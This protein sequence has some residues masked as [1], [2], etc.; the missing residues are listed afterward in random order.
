MDETE[1]K[2]YHD[3]LGMPFTVVGCGIDDILRLLDMYDTFMPE[4]VAQGL[5]PTDKPARLAWIRN[6]LERGENYA[7]IIEGKV[8]G[9]GVLMPGRERHEG[10]YVIFVVRPYRKRGLATALTEMVIQRA[11]ALGLGSVW[12]TV[13]SDNFKAIKLYTKMGFH[14]CDE[15]LSERQ[16]ALLL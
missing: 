13:E 10:E 6:L 4:E 3:K 8:V 16:M 12:L 5:P 1:R 15:G 2:T 14:F 7:A 9:H 11:K